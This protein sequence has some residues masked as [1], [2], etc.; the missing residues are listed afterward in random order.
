MFIQDLVGMSDVNCFSMPRNIPFY[1]SLRACYVLLSRFSFRATVSE[2]V[3][4]MIRMPTR[5]LMRLIVIPL[6]ALDVVQALNSTEKPAFT[7]SIVP[8]S[9]KVR[10]TKR[11]E[12]MT[13]AVEE[14][15]TAIDYYY[16]A[17]EDDGCKLLALL[18]VSIWLWLMNFTLIFG[19]R[20]TRI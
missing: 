16:Y 3:A 19:S 6:L 13:K 9:T 17:G 18:N 2:G 10:T 20:R 7:T 12:T 14:T 8:T 4:S 11:V 1:R 15:T 5:P